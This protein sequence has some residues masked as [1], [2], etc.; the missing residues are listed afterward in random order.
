MDLL[1]NLKTISDSASDP[2]LSEN[3]DNK[4]VLIVEDDKDISDA[5][6]AILSSSGLKVAQAENGLVGLEVAKTFN[7]NVILLDLLMPVMDG[8]TMLK[9]LRELPQF[10][11]TPVIVLTNAGNV[12]NMREAKTYYGAREFLIKSNVGMEELIAKV[13]ALLPR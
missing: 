9:Q 3:Y 7:P 12:D 13:K 6:T 5:F 11:N 10:K 4:K 2:S 1:K 8:K